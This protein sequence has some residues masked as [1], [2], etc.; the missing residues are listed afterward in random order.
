MHRP[1]PTGF[2]L[3][4]VMEL[5]TFASASRV[6]VTPHPEVVELSRRC[7][8]MREAKITLTV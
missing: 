5:T 2:F 4:L 7:Q 3:A 8:N 1:R 6:P